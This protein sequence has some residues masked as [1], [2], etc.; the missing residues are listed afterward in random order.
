MRTVA[1]AVAA[2]EH[3]KSTRQLSSDERQ[4]VYIPLYQSHLPKLDDHDVIHYNQDRGLI[5]P[6][7]LLHVLAPYLEE[8]LYAE[9]DDL[10]PPEDTQSD[11][12]LAGT[13]SA[14]LGR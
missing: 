1:E 2:W 7:P 9:V 11:H 6:T 13:V 4:R 5:E 10:T 3:D 12:H 8:G 14:I